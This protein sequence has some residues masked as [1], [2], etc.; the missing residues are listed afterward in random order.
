M[1]AR[2]FSANLL[3]CWSVTNEGVLIYGRLWKPYISSFT[4]E[5]VQPCFLLSVIEV[6]NLKIICLHFEP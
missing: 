3:L 5:L 2:K 4:D 1:Y 6:C